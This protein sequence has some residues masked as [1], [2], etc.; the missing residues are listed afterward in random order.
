M[1][2]GNDNALFVEGDLD[3]TLRAHFSKAQEIVDAIPD[4]QFLSS[5]DVQLMQE[6][7]NKLDVRPLELVESEKTMLKEE[8]KIDVSHDPSRNMFHR[9]GPLYIDGIRIRVHI[10]FRGDPNLWNLRPNSWRSSF[11]RANIRVSHGKLEGFVEIVIDTPVDEGNERIKQRYESTIDDIK[12]YINNQAAQLKSL[13]PSLSSQIRT[14]IQRRRQRLSAYDNLDDI[15]GIPIKT[16]PEPLRADIPKVVSAK[17]PSSRKQPQKQ[18]DVFISHASEDKEEIVR[19]LANAL[20]EAGLQVWFDEYTLRVGDSLRRSIDKGL[21]QSRYG[22]VI[23]SEPFLQKEWPQKELDGLIAREIDGHKVILPVWHNVSLETVRTNSPLLADRLA[24]SS[25][26]GI[27][28]VVKD[29]L[30]AIGR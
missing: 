2:R 19:P 27:H 8:T 17:T 16:A 24:T 29:L 22:V 7:E 26:K 14:A 18:W 21:A 12:F 5:T 6:V 1:G 11:P 4:K 3:A 28:Q 30:D 9:G 25:E 13:K 23:I 20:Q 15:L 10:P